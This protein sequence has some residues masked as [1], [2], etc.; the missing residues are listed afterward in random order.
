LV[1]QIVLVDFSFF[2]KSRNEEAESTTD[3]KVAAL[4]YLHE[5]LRAGR[6]LGMISVA[7]A[8]G[9]T[10][11]W[12]TRQIHSWKKRQIHSM[13]QAGPAPLVDAL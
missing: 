6:Q 3:S 4:R 8:E 2:R 1:G 11:R 10:S 13:T 9:R 5:T 7:W 12:K